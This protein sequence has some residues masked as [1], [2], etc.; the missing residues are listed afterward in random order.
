MKSAN[1]PFIEIVGVA[2]DGKYL[3]MGLSHERVF[4]CSDGAVFHFVPDIAAALIGAAGKP[5]TEVQNTVR[6]V[7]PNMPI[8]AVQTMK[9]SLAGPQGSWMFRVGATLALAM[10][11]LGRRSR[12]LECTEWFRLRRASGLT[13]LESAWR[14]R[15]AAGHPAAG[16]RA[17]IDVGDRG[18]AFRDA[19]CVGVDA[20]NGYAV[21]RSKPH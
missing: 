12:W 19:G 7:D 11:I 2:K 6:S 4:L 10:G 17:R 20:L 18:R 16:F 9:E 5:I 13:R 15:R 1:G 3:F 8:M 21:D 14:R